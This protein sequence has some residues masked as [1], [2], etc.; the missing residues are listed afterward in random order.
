MGAA[1]TGHLEPSSL[2]IGSAATEPALGS[3]K[4]NDEVGPTALPCEDVVLWRFL[5]CGPSPLL[6][7]A[8]FFVAASRRA[9]R[10]ESDAGCHP[11][12]GT[13]TILYYYYY[14][15]YYYTILYYTIAIRRGQWSLPPSVP[16]SAR[17]VH[18]SSMAS[19]HPVSAHGSWEDMVSI[20]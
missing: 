7:R 1:Q 16:G 12:W 3:A 13:Y 6:S 15:Y 9:L 10:R 20:L 17:V 5:R 4:V 8:S 14:Y 18:V 19:V 2:P 11:A